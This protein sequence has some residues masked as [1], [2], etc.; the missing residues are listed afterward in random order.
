MKKTMVVATL[1]GWCLM[2][3]TVTVTTPTDGGGWETVQFSSITKTDTRIPKQ[4][5]NQKMDR[6]FYKSAQEML[7][8][9]GSRGMAVSWD[10]IRASYTTYASGPDPVVER[11]L[12]FAED[13]T[14]C[15]GFSFSR[16]DRARD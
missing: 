5:R 14:E 1:F 16:F 11:K 7:D 8:G 9:W 12:I 6:V 3:K 15:D 2:T 4:V 10:G 13:K